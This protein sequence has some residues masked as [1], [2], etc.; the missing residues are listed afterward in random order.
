MTQN[1][2]HS[3]LMDGINEFML[4]YLPKET[5]QSL[6][7]IYYYAGGLLNTFLKWE[8]NGQKESAE[9][10]ARI[11]CQHTRS[12]LKCAGFFTVRA[13]K[14]NCILYL[15]DQVYIRIIDTL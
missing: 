6:Y 13:W 4:S 15:L 10:V 14:R 5:V 11:I 12:R 7:D 3:I 1:G 2:L 8:E 9:E